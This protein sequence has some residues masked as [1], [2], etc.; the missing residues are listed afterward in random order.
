MKVL[1]G[2]FLAWSYFVGKIRNDQSCLTMLPDGSCQSIRL[3]S[4]QHTWARSPIARAST[5]WSC[6]QDGR[7][8]AFSA[9][10]RRLRLHTGI[11]LREGGVKP[12]RAMGCWIGPCW[13][14]QPL[15]VSPHQYSWGLTPDSLFSRQAKRGLQPSRIRAAGEFSKA[16]HVCKQ[17]RQCRQYTRRG[18]PP[19][20][21]TFAHWS[22]PSSSRG[23]FFQKGM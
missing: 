4:C 19:P 1:C 12:R 16:R 7:Q 10:G 9:G 13:T 21:L 2:P 14:M 18:P 23:D 17:Y 3:L 15:W 5:S 11:T 22:A 6:T 8:A 20:H